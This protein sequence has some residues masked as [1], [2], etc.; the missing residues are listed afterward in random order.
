MLG[1]LAVLFVL[2]DSRDDE[3][4]PVNWIFI[5]VLGFGILLILLGKLDAYFSRTWV[6]VRRTQLDEL[7]KNYRELVAAYND[8][9]E[10]TFGPMVGTLEGSRGEVHYW[11]IVCPDGERRLVPSLEIQEAFDR[12]LLAGKSGYCDDV[13][14][15]GEHTV[16]ERVSREDG[17]PKHPPHP[18]TPIDVVSAY[19]P[20][21]VHA[22]C[23]H[24]EDC[25]RCGPCC[26][27]PPDDR[28]APGEHP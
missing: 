13:C 6:L 23:P 18:G 17:L 4:F 1:T 21:L 7:D 8:L 26:T 14:P 2:L 28:E 19:P 3:V 25:L 9:H 20:E 22:R 27:K 11:S 15:G 12:A 10:Q 16:V 24:C 5:G